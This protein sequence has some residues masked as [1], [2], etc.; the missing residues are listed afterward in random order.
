[1][2]EC[3][4]FPSFSLALPPTN[5]QRKDVLMHHMWNRIASGATGT[6]HQLSHLRSA[7]AQN[8][9]CN[10][11]PHARSYALRVGRASLSNIDI[12]RRVFFSPL[13]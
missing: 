7:T 10:A 1:M 9:S 12:E 11:S 2:N 5:T 3:F 4:F 13:V 8:V 6:C